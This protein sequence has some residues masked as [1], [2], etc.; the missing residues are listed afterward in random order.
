MKPYWINILGMETFKKTL[1]EAQAGDNAGVLVKGVKREDLRR[2]MVLTKPG[3]FTQHKR[4][5]VQIYLLTKDEG[6]QNRPLLDE[7]VNMIYSLTWNFPAYA[8]LSGNE[9]AKTIE[10]N[11]VDKKGN[12]MGKKHR[13]L[14]MPGEDAKLVF[15]LTRAMPFDVGQ[16]FTI[17]TGEFT[18]GTGIVTKLL[19]DDEWNEFTRNFGC[20]CFPWIR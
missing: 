2:G 13:K 20:Y 19:P 15:K 14:I 5:E 18:L 11:V 4:V 8:D 10:Q 9:T 17:R 3:M 6:G 7:A 16:R 1:D 12:D